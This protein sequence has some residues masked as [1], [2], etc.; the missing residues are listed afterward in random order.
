MNTKKLAA[1][2]AAGA[3][4]FSFTTTAALLQPAGTALAAEAIKTT[5]SF[6]DLKNIDASFKARLN[7][8]LA[9]GIFDG[10]SSD[11]FGLH[12]PMTRAQFAKVATL[13]FGIKVDSSVKVSSFSDVRADDSAN[14]W[15]IPYIEAARKAGLIEGVTDTTFAP[16]AQVTA[17]QLDTILLKGLGKKV[18]ATG[19]PWFADAVK[20]AA[21]LSIH[22]IG[23]TGDIAADRAD[24]VNSSY[25]ARDL[26]EEQ[27]K[28]PV[29]PASISSV[30][31]SGDKLKVQ[32]E[33]DT[34][35]DTA[36]ATLALKKGDT[37]V[38]A[39]TS[40]SIDKKSATL[41]VSTELTPGDYTV[42]L[43]GLDAA[44]IKLATRTLTVSGG[45][46]SGGTNYDTLQTYEIANVR[47][48]GLTE[49]ATGNNGLETRANAENPVMSKFAKE[50]KVK[51]TSGGEEV[52]V[53][54]IIQAM[55][56][57]NPSVVDVGVSDDNRGYILGNKAGTATLN[58]MLRTLNGDTKQIQATVVVKSDSVNGQELKAGNT[59][60]THDLSASSEFDA[61]EAMDLS[62]TDNYGIKYEKDEIRKYN[63][64]LASLFMVNRIEGDGTVQVTQD[65]KVH[66]IGTVTSF[67]LTSVL[68]NRK[69]VTTFVK[70]KPAE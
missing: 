57:S 70:V 37:V 49:A 52:A 10:V 55:T 8:M 56:T 42:T 69:Q 39:V 41:T 60:Y 5:D 44:A 36:K 22:P 14:S 31:A 48:S 19:T 58:I 53:P 16:G 24:L 32:V 15:A 3:M 67:E 11:T 18:D 30:T 35:V 1:L 4:A 6:Q 63:F 21:A 17:G 45:V 27:T 33:L 50:I 12:D 25:A 40:W 9:D 20:Q 13:I 47:D 64:A 65:G 7:A 2:V 26:H 59:S 61:Y 34:A 46:S 68:P 54:G 62:I 43:G 23:K 29:V 51:V 28:P 38:S 66:I